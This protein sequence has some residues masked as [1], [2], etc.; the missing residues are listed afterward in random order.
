MK[1]SPGHIQTFFQSTSVLINGGVPILE[2]LESVQRQYREPEIVQAIDGII[3]DLSSGF[4]L[5]KALARAE[6]FSDLEIGLIQIGER[7]G[8]LHLVLERLAKLAE[9]RLHLRQKLRSALAYP[10]FVLVLCGLLLVFAPVLVFQDML[11]L[12]E[13]MHTD[14]PLATDVYLAFSR[15]LHH[16]IFY[17][18]FAIL[19]GLSVAAVRKILLD[20]ELRLKGEEFIFLIPWLSDALKASAVAEMSGA[21]CVS[22]ESGLPI[23]E[24][25]RLAKRATWSRLLGQDIDRVRTRVKQGETLS[26]ALRTS[27]FFTSLSLC[28]ISSGEESGQVEQA[29]QMVYEENKQMVVERLERFQQLLEPLLLLGVG[30]FVGFIAVALLAPTISLVEGL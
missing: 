24:S 21:L 12:L 4:P 14:L 6:V 2:S 11:T 15:M 13:E 27:E 3:K 28:M 8:K 16:P 17:F 18:I 30:I 25:F 10:A 26:E 9:E 20:R 7:S 1:W 22:Y 5:H 29:L 19:L 23:L